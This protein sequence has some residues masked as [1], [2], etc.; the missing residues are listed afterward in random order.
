MF[1]R[2]CFCVCNLVTLLFLFNGLFGVD[3]VVADGTSSQNFR[4]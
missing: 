4:H 1:G 2:L 3:S